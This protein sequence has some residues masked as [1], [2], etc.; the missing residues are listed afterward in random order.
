[1][2]PS[3][4]ILAHEKEIFLRISQGDEAAFTEM[5]F[6]YTAR[7]HPFIK[8]MT[9]SEEITE[10]IVQDVFVSL[11]RNREKLPEIN[12]YTAYIFTIASNRTFNYLKTKAREIVRLQE[13]T[14]VEK[15]FTN[16][17]EETID[18]NESK[19]LINKLVNRLTP[20]KKLIYQLTREQGL[21]HDEIAVQ[22]NISKNTV[23][24][25]L[26]QTL[27]FLRENLTNRHSSSLILVNIFIEIYS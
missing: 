1:M 21:S 24:N 2:S 10:E 15:S 6:H 16:V 12:N 23:K 18:L 9:R 3:S 4:T 20:Q 14:K 19:D 7:I 8:K 25:H 27:K 22:L 5:F 26:V 11:W 17:T 13:L